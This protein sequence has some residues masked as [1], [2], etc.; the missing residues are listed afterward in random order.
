MIPKRLSMVAHGKEDQRSA[1]IMLF[2]DASIME[3]VLGLISVI[4][5]E[6]GQGMIAPHLFASKNAYT[7]EIVLLPMYV[8]VKEVGVVVTALLHCVRKNAAMAEYALLQIHANVTS[9]IIYGEMVELKEEFLCFR[10]QT[11]THSSL[12]GRKCFLSILV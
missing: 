5:Q 9:G 11:E 3:L 6:D 7:T 8:H 1:L 12:V 4:V 10:S 2:E